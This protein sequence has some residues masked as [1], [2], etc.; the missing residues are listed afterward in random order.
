M[1]DHRDHVAVLRRGFVALSALSV[2]ATAVELALIRHWDSTIQLIPWLALAA[3]AVAVVLVLGRP[4]R[5]RVQVVR[6]LALAVVLTATVGVFEHVK[7]NYDAAPLD[8]RYTAKWPTMSAGSRWW[9]AATQS[10]GPS[11]T[12]APGVLAQAALCLLFATL[13]HPGLAVSTV[14]PAVAE[15]AAVGTAERDHA[16]R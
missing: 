15:G 12:L 7:A 9:A 11:P 5:R 16:T 8:F 2:V 1:S 13:G 3:M 6:V 14:E 4:G 10:V